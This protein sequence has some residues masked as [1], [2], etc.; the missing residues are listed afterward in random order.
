MQTQEFTL[1]FQVSG[2]ILR[3][4]QQGLSLFILLSISSLSNFT[5]W[6]CIDQMNDRRQEIKEQERPEASLLRIQDIKIA[7]V[8]QLD[9]DDLNLPDELKKMV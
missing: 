9:D 3:C 1:Y 8:N 6:Y 2:L 7:Q 4:S 5:L